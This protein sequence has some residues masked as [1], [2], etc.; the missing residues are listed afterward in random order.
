MS[1]SGTLGEDEHHDW[2]ERTAWFFSVVAVARR[3][4]LVADRAARRPWR[5]PARM[6]LLAATLGG[7]YSCSGR[8]T[9]AG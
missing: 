4:L 8:R 1:A 5:L 2:A 9:G 3:V 7:Q 6:S